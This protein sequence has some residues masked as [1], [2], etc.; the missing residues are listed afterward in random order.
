M[1]KYEYDVAL[2]FAGEDRQY[3]EAL[4]SLLKSDKYSVFYD[5][6]EQA[7]LWGKNIYEHLSSIYKDKARYCVMFLS[8]HYAQKLWPNHERRS[9]QARAFEENQEYILPIR[10]D[11]TEIPGVLS[12]VGYLDLRSMSIEEIYKILV[13]KLSGT[14]SQT[15]PTDISPLAAAESAP[16]EYVLLHIEDGKQYFI[17]FRDAHW[18]PKEISLNLL[19]ES[20]EQVAFLS[21]LRDSVRKHFAQ[22][23]M[24]AFALREDAA[25]VSPQ[26]AAQAMSG[27]QT[28]WR[29]VLKLK[30]GSRGQGAGIL[31][32]SPVN[33][34]SFNNISSDQI[35]KMR[36]RRILL[37]EKLGGI[38]QT[39]LVGLANDPTLESF[40]RDGT[41][42]SSD[43]GL[44]IQESPIPNLYKSFSQTSERFLKFARLASV[45]YLKLSN[46]VEH[47]LELDLEPLNLK[48][49]QVSFKGRRRQ[50]HINVEPS[51][52]QVNGTCP[53]E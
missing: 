16:G 35:A 25:W 30:E 45:L 4:A 49:L 2:S 9:A 18:A 50:R 20:P 46:T 10:L 39:G 5:E 34:I 11:D 40:I 23:N 32:E 52:I 38:N 15:I 3:A 6:Y 42:L 41:L 1:K 53:L 24:L 51:I 14:T 48:Q 7:T 33:N 27:S 43:L 28:V 19:P 29:L 26:E 12:T 47:I 44:Q 36:A 21:S 17:P 13:N 31:N 8:Q 37:N 22:D